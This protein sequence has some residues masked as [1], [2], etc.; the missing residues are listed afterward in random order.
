MPVKLRKA[1]LKFVSKESPK[2][3]R[4]KAAQGLVE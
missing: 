3:I 4:L 1:L 2:E